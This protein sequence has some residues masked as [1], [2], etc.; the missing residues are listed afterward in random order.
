MDKGRTA[1]LGIGIQF[2][3]IGLLLLF[4]TSLQ[5]LPQENKGRLEIHV[6]RPDSTDGVSGVT[7]TLQGPYPLAST[8]LVSG[9]YTPN[10]KLTPEMRQQVDALIA[11]APL[12]ISPEVVANAAVRMEANLLGLPAPPNTPN[13]P[14]TAPPQLNGM[15]DASGNY[16]FANLA[17]GR[18]QVRAQREGYFGAPP[19]GLAGISLPTTVSTTAT[20]D[21]SKPASELSMTMVRGATVSGRVRDPNGQPL[22]GVQVYAYQVAY[23]NGRTMLQS[24]NSKQTDDRGDFRLFY[25]P[26]GDYFI[27]TLPRRTTN[28]PSSMDSYARTFYPGTSDGKSASQV[29]VTEGG[30]II[31]IDINV[32]A[33][34]TAKI[35]GRVLTTIVGPTGQAPQPGTFYLMP[36]DVNTFTDTQGMNFPNMSANRTNGQFEIR[37][38]LPGSYDLITTLS[39]TANGG[40]SIGRAHVEVGNGASV[41]DVTLNVKSGIP[42]KA[43]LVL[44]TGAV[45][46]T[47]QPPTARG[48]IVIINGVPQA[49]PTPTTPVPTPSIRLNFRSMEAYPSPFDSAASQYTYDPAAGEFIFP[50]VPEGRYYIT[51]AP[52]PVNSYIADVQL[53]GRSVFDSGFELG[54]QSGDLEVRI[55]SKGAKIQGLALDA[56]QNPVATARVVLVPEESRRQNQALYK[57]A[58]SDAKGNFTLSGIAPGQYKLY[59]WESLPGTAY[60]NPEFMAKY[61]AQGQVV[62]VLEGAT[63]NA[64]AKVI[65]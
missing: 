21:P 58:V 29:K 38:V 23:Q 1:P 10:P 51:A 12:G 39:D 34:A 18:Y 54:G 61:D 55:S 26:P 30:D 37:G 19:P 15:T 46:Y 41:E 59:A 8:D 60:M 45:S 16:V 64:N 32:R 33:D 49:A 36:R 22:S 44:D 24:L 42:V 62:K 7:L 20:V 3:G 50:N 47:M 13:G 14:T 53:G 52:V 25:L 17:P 5:I 31:G 65:R 2:A 56:A 63:N 9:L 11:S 35:S 6:T 40:Q 4:T 28:V 57:T 43:K 48:G 27:G